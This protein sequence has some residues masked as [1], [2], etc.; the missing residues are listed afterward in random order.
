MLP[1]T[2]LCPTQVHIHLFLNFSRFVA[3]ILT[4]MLARVIEVVH[5]LMK[6][7][8]PAVRKDAIEVRLF[9]QRTNLEYLCVMSYI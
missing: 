8:Y 1:R 5:F 2:S 4:L 9:A 3:L 6:Y 7:V